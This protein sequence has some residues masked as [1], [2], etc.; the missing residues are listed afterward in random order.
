MNNQFK[1]IL[2]TAIAALVVLIGVL[3]TLLNSDSN[4]STEAGQPG[5][6]LFCFWNVENFFDDEDNGLKR[7]PD[8]HY[9]QLFSR[10]KELFQRKVENLGKV[11]LQLNG[12]KGPDILALA[13]VENQNAATRLQEHLNE[14]L[15]NRAEP[16][17]NL[18][19]LNPHGG[20]DIATVI[21]TRLPVVRD[22]TV[23]L[24]S[25][26]RILEG[27][28]VVNGQELVVIASHWTSRLTDKPEEG[29][30]RARYADMIYGRFR[31]MYSSNAQV[32]LLV[33]GD[34]ND[35]PQDASVTKHLHT[36]TEENLLRK[37]S[38]EPSMFNLFAGP[39]FAGKG[40]L[41]YEGKHWLFDQI[42]V[43]PGLLEKGGWMCDP[44]SA[45]IVT[46]SADREG[47]PEGFNEKKSTGYSDHLPVTV[48]LSVQGK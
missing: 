22:R 14:K 4:P 48:R 18:L 24:G 37:I 34:F 41:C 26:L 17:K 5:E 23:L 1:T 29:T 10:N 45:T 39:A 19:Y 6:Y 31:A 36:T 47:C 3:L 46:L 11:L 21:L 40:T 33:C 42:V 2:G 43:S 13:E 8:K 9:D 15:G 27:H 30:S 16:Y 20:R 25:R 12:G 32:D 44:A 35:T 38:P 28:L 7:D